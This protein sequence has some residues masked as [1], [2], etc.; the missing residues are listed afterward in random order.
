MD[1]ACCMHAVQAVF[2]GKLHT[3]EAFLGDLPEKG[4]QMAAENV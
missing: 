4:E 3:L 2:D 1:V